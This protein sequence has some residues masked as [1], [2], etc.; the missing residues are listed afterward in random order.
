[1]HSMTKYLH[2]SYRTIENNIEVCKHSKQRKISVHDESRTI[3]HIYKQEI[4]N[5]KDDDIGCDK[6]K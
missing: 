3:V 2:E 4:T 1:M 5:D 6:G